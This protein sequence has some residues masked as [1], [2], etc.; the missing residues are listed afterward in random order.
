MRFVAPEFLWLLLLVPFGAFAS[1]IR[2]TRRNRALRRFAGG[3]AYVSRFTEE[4]SW[5]RRAA[6]LLLI[7]ATMIAL[8]L[9]LARPQWGTSLEEITRSGGDVI[10]VLDTSLSMAAEDVAPN[11]LDQ[12]K[13][14]IVSL[15]GRLE[16]DRV[17]LVT[18]A[19]QANLTCPLTVDHGAVRLFLE[20]VGPTSV[21]V[22]GTALADALKLARRAL[23]PEGGQAEVDRG[24]AVVVYSDGEDHEGGLEEA[25]DGYR[26]AGIAIHAVGSGTTRGAPIPLRDS[27]GMLSGYKKDREDKV[28]T[29]RLDE[30][31]LERLALDTEGSYFRATAGEL[32]IDQIARTLGGLEGG[33]L[34]KQ[35]RMRYEDRF[36]IPLL[37]GWLALA[38]ETLLGDRRRS[39]A[40][41]LREEAGR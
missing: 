28:V 29:T 1:W 20:S 37:L 12:A 4:I 22:G 35:L 5:N 16:G 11:R 25:L 9:A 13:H 10:V 31:V 17:G 3:E 32:E 23:L 39:R 8:P 7:M 26:S 34:G 6:K 21:T 33:E 30:G 14:A 18:F 38:A 41:R 36:Q 15:L 27:T 24:R 19:G 2:H 40:G